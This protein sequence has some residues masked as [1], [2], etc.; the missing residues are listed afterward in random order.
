MIYHSYLL[1]NEC[2]HPIPINNSFLTDID[3]NSGDFNGSD[4]P[5]SP[6]FPDNKFLCTSLNF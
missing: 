2:R 4:Y 5:V 3:L 1:E 6:K